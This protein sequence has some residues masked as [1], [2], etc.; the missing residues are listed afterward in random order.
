[1]VLL[2]D[3][4]AELR[5]VRDVDAAPE[6]EHSL[7]LRPLCTPDRPDSGTGGLQRGGGLG[8]D[9]LLR[10]FA[11]AS[12]DVPQDLVLLAGGDETLQGTDV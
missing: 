11:V 12:A 7:V 1:M 5:D 4:V 9:V 10:T 3:P 2:D 8:D 6:H